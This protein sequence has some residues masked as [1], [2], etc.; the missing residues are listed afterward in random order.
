[1][2]VTFSNKMQNLNA[3]ANIEYTHLGCTMENASALLFTMLENTHR[4]NVMQ[5][6]MHIQFMPM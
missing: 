4:A 2:R 3:S 6:Y 1:M 5:R